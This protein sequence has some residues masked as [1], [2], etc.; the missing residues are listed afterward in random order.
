MSRVRYVTAAIAAATLAATAGWF[1][2]HHSS[3]PASTFVLLDGTSASTA[4]L[5]GKVTLVN[6]WTT[7]CTACVTEMDRLVA[8]YDRYH[9]KGYD[10]LAIAMGSDSPMN[11]ALYSETRRLPF[12]VAIDNSGSLAKAWGDVA[13]TPTTF[14][15]DRH[16]TIVK[17]YVGEP[18]FAELQRLIEKLLAA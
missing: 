6:F 11:V 2:W 16:G 13:A 12:K 3:A 1:N 18:D 14:L 17:R 4:D 8:T 5:Q 10:T 15:L 7:G 9:A